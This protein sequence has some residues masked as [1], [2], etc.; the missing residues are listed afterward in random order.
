M[1][2]NGT[3]GLCWIFGIICDRL[4]SCTTEKGA[5]GGGDTSKVN[6]FL[7]FIS[8]LL[9]L[10]HLVLILYIRGEKRTISY[11]TSISVIM[12]PIYSIY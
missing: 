11:V 1:Y 5:F 12:Y 10:K 2:G 4:V 9:R 3:I 6:F 7:L 8:S